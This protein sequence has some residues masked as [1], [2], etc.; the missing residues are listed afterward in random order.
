MLEQEV[1]LPL[2]TND[3]YRILPDRPFEFWI[4]SGETVEMFENL[5]KL[6]FF[7]EAMARKQQD[8]DLQENQFDFMDLSD[9]FLAD[10]EG[11]GS[12]EKAIIR[13]PNVNKNVIMPWPGINSHSLNRKNLFEEQNKDP[14]VL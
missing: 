3:P 11:P 5:Y 13:P 10:I 6:L 4:V 8:E 14:E 7:H 1:S 12:S 9:T 2:S